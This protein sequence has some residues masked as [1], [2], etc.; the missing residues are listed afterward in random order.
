MSMTIAQFFNLQKKKVDDDVKVVI[1][2]IV[3]AFSMDDRTHETDEENM[4][5]PKI[6][7][8][9]AMQA[10]H[11]LCFYEKQNVNEDSELITCINC[12]KRVI[13]VWGVKGL[14]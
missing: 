13:R 12:Y 10:L 14:K 3:K 8:T 2:K 7:Y 5:I 11:K 9:K 1:N 4:I 6:G